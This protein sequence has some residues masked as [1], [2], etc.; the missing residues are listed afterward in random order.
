M[1]V[2]DSDVSN[3]ISTNKSIIMLEN[4]NKKHNNSEYTTTN[5]HLEGKMSLLYD[6]KP[7]LK[8]PSK[9]FDRKNIIYLVNRARTNKHK[10]RKTIIKDTENEKVS[11]DIPLKSSRIKKQE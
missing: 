8:S 10:S 5:I 2:I 3:K 7:R 9:K 4:D 11:L 6:N 1:R